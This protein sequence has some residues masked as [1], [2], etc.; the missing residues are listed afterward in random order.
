ME[1]AG[2]LELFL[3]EKELRR[4]RSEYARDWFVCA[5]VSFNHAVRKLVHRLAH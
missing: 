5:V 3:L 1:R 2:K 4:L